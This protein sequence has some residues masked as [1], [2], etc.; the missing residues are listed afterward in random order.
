ME[1]VFRMKQLQTRYRMVERWL[2]QPTRTNHQNLG[3]Q[4]L[5]FLQNLSEI[6]EKL[7]KRGLRIE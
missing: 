2:N 3:T 4:I 6:Q 7:S 5:Q 1:Q